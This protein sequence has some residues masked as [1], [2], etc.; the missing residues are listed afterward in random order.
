VGSAL[1]GGPSQPLQ[2]LLLKALEPESADQETSNLRKVFARKR[3]I[4]LERLTE[5][6]I[7]CFTDPKGSATFYI[8]GFIGK[9]PAPFNLG[10]SFFRNALE[11]RVMVVPGEF[12][13]VNPGKR[14]ET[15]QYLDWVRFS[16]GPPEARMIEGLDRLKAMLSKSKC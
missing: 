8:W 10:M 6:G 9:L 12:F 16:F 13:D 11:H 1:D 3:M 15:T 4:M 2:E 14:R 7:E 5:M